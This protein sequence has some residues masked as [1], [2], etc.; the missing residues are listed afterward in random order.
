VPAVFN[1]PA[2]VQWQDGKPMLALPYMQ[3]LLEMAGEGKV[4]GQL[5]GMKA[6]LTISECLSK[7]ELN[8]RR[9]ATAAFLDQQ[10]R[11]GVELCG[12]AMINAT[13]PYPMPLYIKLKSTG[14]RK[15]GGSV[16]ILHLGGEYELEGQ[17]AETLLGATITLKSTKNIKHSGTGLLGH[18]R[19]FNLDLLW[20]DGKPKIT[21]KQSGFQGALVELTPVSSE[22][23]AADRERMNHLLEAGAAFAKV[24]M[25]DTN[26]LFQMQ[27][28][29]DGTGDKVVGTFSGDPRIAPDGT[30]IEGEI[31]E[32]NGFV[33]MNLQ[34][35][36]GQDARKRPIPSAKFWLW[37]LA[38]G[39]QMNLGGYYIPAGRN[40]P[41]PDAVMMKQAEP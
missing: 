12:P 20:E 22:K 40:P 35:A 25:G 17:A 36:T 26:R 1:Q 4:S 7:E 8:Q 34:T 33:F 3:G 21:G 32:A 23:L 9:A 5:N 38:E 28:K 18:G 27:L 14:Q 29:R 31:S 13:N 6:T 30:A 10:L 39:E 11:E 37:A 24:G 41:T 19:D 2:V 15:L 16:A